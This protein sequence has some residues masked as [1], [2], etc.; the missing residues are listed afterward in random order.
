MATVAAG[1]GALDLNV[2]LSAAE[3][4]VAG[5]EFLSGIP[6]T[7]GGGLRMN[8][9]AY[10]RE[11]KDVLVSAAAL[12]RAGGERVVAAAAMGFVLPPLRGRPRIG[13]LSR[14]GFAA[15]AAT[16]RRSARRMAEIQRRA[17]GDA[18]RSAPAPAARPSPTRPATRRG[19]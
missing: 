6:G 16:R 2:A 11:V 1:A 3:A 8:A 7:V 14:R 5:L 13:S 9:G 10:G 17:R 19:G 12:D 15:S 4:G 18:S